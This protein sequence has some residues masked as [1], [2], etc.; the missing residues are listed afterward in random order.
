MWMLAHVCMHLQEYVCSLACVCMCVLCVYI[1][2]HVCVCACMCVCVATHV[3]G[4]YY[5]I[6]LYTSPIFTCYFE[7]KFYTKV[8][9][10]LEFIP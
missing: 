7:T 5:T 1:A 10:G 4:K 9:T 3:L 6:Q 2:T 8:L